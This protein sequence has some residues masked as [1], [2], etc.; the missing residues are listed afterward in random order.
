MAEP[1]EIKS[2]VNRTREDNDPAAFSPKP[3]LDENK[4][5]GLRG[6]E[7]IRFRA[8][9]SSRAIRTLPFGWE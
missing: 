6:K 8:T 2:Q 5:A 9:S 7:K 3:V 1:S 4:G